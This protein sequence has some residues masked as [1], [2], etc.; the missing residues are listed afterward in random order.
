MRKIREVL[1]LKLDLH[2]SDREISESC[3]LGRAT[4]AR[5]LERAQ[6]ANLTWP[7][8]E[9]LDDKA[10]EAL[11]FRRAACKNAATPV[12]PTPDWNAVH[13][14]LKRKGVTRHLLWKEFKAQ[15]PTAWGYTWFTQ[16]YRAWRDAQNLTM[17]QTHKAGEKLFVDYAG[18]TVPITNPETGEVRQ[19]QVF[20]ATLGASNYTFVEVTLTQTVEDWLS[21]HRR[22]LEFFGGTP[23]VIVPDNLKAGVKSPCYYEPEINRAYAE[24]ARHYELA[25][26]PTRVRK[27]RDKA[28]VEV[29][30]QIVERHVLAPL[31]NR[32]F[33]SLREA[34][35]A[36]SELLEALN[37]MPFQKLEGSR[38]TLFESVDRP[39]LRPLPS[40]PF[41]PGEWR[42]AKVNIDYHV[43]IDGHYYSVPYK[44]ARETVDV[45]LTS[46]TLEVFLNNKRI[47]AHARALDL[48]RHR[49][50][51]TTVADH[52]PKSHQRHG[53]WS[54]QRLLNWASKNGP[55]TEKVVQQILESRTH[56]EQGYRSCLGLMRLTKTFGADRLEAA[57]KRADHLRAYS[58]KSVQSILQNKLD[59]EPILLEENRR[60]VQFVH[61]NLRGA[62]YYKKEDSVSDTETRS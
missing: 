42:K 37:A 26:I 5:Y 55:F 31:R 43:E 11:L 4:I 52:M 24:F 32:T 58:F 61:G 59:L 54:P 33:F 15:Q 46:N 53:D 3:R 1:R 28:K 60:D 38:K 39:A 44:H 9:E 14:E 41:T 48:P 21:S 56:P 8:P 29:G 47:A 27:P 20:V 45:R 30:V 2:R 13:T 57:C 7:L 16:T 17:R 35:A 19:A 6:A 23:E 10:L 25:I 51:H 62:A 18:M 49:G 12:P 36:I 22:A 34:N 40:E 50:R